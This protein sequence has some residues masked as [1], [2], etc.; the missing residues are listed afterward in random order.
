MW[1]EG[2]EHTVGSVPLV[3]ENEPVISRDCFGFL[4]AV[5]SRVL[6]FGKLEA[7]KAL[8]ANPSA[9]GKKG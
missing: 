5:H 4:H 9:R 7:L 1:V 2:R 3:L 6:S 8:Y